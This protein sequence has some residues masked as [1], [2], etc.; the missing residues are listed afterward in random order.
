[1]S[2][3]RLQG[4]SDGSNFRQL[5]L[6]NDVDDRGFSLLRV[7]PRV[8][9]VQARPWLCRAWA[10]SD[11]F[12]IFGGRPGHVIYGK[13]VAGR[14]HRVD[15]RAITGVV[16]NPQDARASSTHGDARD[17]AQPWRAERPGPLKQRRDGILGEAWP[18]RQYV[19]ENRHR[20]DARAARA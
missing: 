20:R 11:V 10:Q 9:E 3:A 13:E 5:R 7:I 16:V 19:H 8:G 17:L 6:R 1:M 15:R 2:R 12:P 14:I 18:W 4:L